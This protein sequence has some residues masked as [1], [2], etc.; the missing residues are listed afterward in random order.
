MDLG[1]PPLRMKT[2]LESSPLKSRFFVLWTDL[3]CRSR[4]QSASA[5]SVGACSSVLPDACSLRTTVGT[6]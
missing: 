5:D 6:G 2:P 4:A 3:A 1:I